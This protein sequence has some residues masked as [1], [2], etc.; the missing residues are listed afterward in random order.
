MVTNAKRKKLVEQRLRFGDCK[1]ICDLGNSS[2][3]KVDKIYNDL[4]SNGKADYLEVT[5]REGVVLS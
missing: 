5:E 1:I 4:K 2:F 3:K